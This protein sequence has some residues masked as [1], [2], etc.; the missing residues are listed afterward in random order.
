M[1]ILGW[2]GLCST[3]SSFRA[4]AGRISTTWKSGIWL[5]AIAL[6]SN[7]I[8]CILIGKRFSLEERNVTY[9]LL[10]KARA[11]KGSPA[12]CPEGAEPEILGNCPNC[13]QK[14]QMFPNITDIKIFSKYFNYVD[15]FANS[16]LLKIFLFIFKRGGGKE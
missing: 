8:E 1:C 7:R 10:I 14:E 16:F 4:Q 9:T 6:G 12:L 15:N 3:L 13:N 11:G 5:S 2:W